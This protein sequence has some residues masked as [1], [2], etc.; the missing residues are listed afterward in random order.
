MAL[1]RKR[2]IRPGVYNIPQVDPNKPDELISNPIHIGKPRIKGFIE[3]FNRMTRNGLSVPAPFRHDEKAEPIR[4]NG[5]AQDS[6]AYTNAGFWKHLWQ[7]KEGSLWGE[8]DVPNETDIEKLNTTVEDVSLL[9]KPEWQDGSGNRYDDAIT[10]IALVTHPVA[11]DDTPFVPTEAGAT[12]LSLS[13]FSEEGGAGQSIGDCVAL[14]QKLEPPVSL[15]QSTTIDNFVERLATALNAIV[16]VIESGGAANSSVTKPPK[17]SKEQNGPI[18]M[19]LTLTQA[20]SLL[21]ENKIVN[22]TTKEA[23]T[24]EDISA[25]TPEAPKPPAE[26]LELSLED[27]AAINFARK[28]ATNDYKGR[29]ERCVSLGKITPATAKETALP[30]LEDLK[31]SFDAEG[32]RQKAPLDAV[33]EAWEAIPSHSTLTGMNSATAKA[34]PTGIFSDTQAFSLEST[35]TEESGPDFN[36]PANHDDLESDEDHS[37]MIMK[38]AGLK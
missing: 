13:L 37:D 14:L 7:D 2:I 38:L 3:T 28:V 4:T 12:A 19:S 21:A 25:L 31:L 1:F 6:D 26:S 32:E 10:H 16:P 29:I 9:A 11:K 17:G 23:F 22:P 35:L 34:T 30:F 8:V 27:K 5:D 20:L 18:A 33:L 24:P 15:P 36:A